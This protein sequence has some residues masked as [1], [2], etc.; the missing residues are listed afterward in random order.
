MS[1]CKKKEVVE[2]TGPSYD[3]LVA[4][5]NNLQSQLS[6]LENELTDMKEVLAGYAPD[7][8]DTDLSHVQVLDTGETAYLSIDNKIYIDGDLELDENLKDVSPNKVKLFVGDNVSISPGENWTYTT[9]NNALEMKH[10]DGMYLSFENIRYF[11]RLG[12]VRDY[13]EKY[14]IP[15]FKMLR[16]GEPTIRNIFTEDNRIIGFIATVKMPVKVL[17]DGSYKLAPPEFEPEYLVDENGNQILDEYGLPQ[18]LAI[19]KYGEPVYDADGNRV[20]IKNEA[21]PVKEPVYLTDENGNLVWQT[22]ENGDII[23]ATDEKGEIIYQKDD[24][25]NIIYQTD[26][27]GNLVYQKDENGEDKPIPLVQGIPIEVE[28]T[29]TPVVADYT[30]EEYTYNLALAY[31]SE[32]FNLV[33]VKAYYKN[34]GLTDAMQSDFFDTLMKSIELNGKKFQLE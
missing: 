7:L 13:D 25:G 29:P 2:E 32:S 20:I 15:Y 11:D 30:M 1:G 17:D 8:V 10:R 34:N 23:P 4:N 19:D 21:P 5:N 3:E 31:D 14:I 24:E 9:R 18:Q 16:L 6:N 12:D 28:E 22:D 27:E 33:V 26:E